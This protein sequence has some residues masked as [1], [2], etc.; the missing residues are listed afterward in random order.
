MPKRMVLMVW[1]LANSDALIMLFMF[2]SFTF[3][4]SKKKLPPKGKP[5]HAIGDNP[6]AVQV[7]DYQPAR[8]AFISFLR[9]HWNTNL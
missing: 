6:C 7:S 1:M 5:T 8:T 4:H 9:L 2:V 3:H